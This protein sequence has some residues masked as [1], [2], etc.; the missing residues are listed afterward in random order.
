MIL[1]II[2]FLGKFLAGICSFSIFKLNLKQILQKKPMKLVIDSKILFSLVTILR[3]LHSGVEGH[4]KHFWAGWAISISLRR[5]RVT[6]NTFRPVWLRFNH[7]GVEGSS[8]T[9]LG[10]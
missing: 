4:Q 5:R 9:L 1:F 8:K 7:S 6:Q 10:R 3:L 2:F